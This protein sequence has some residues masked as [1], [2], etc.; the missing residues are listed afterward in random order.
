MPR[1]LCRRERTASMPCHALQCDVHA[2]S[3][4]HT[5]ESGRHASS[6]RSSFVFVQ[7][8][9]LPQLTSHVPVRQMCSAR[10]SLA[11]VATL[12]RRLS[13]RR[14][15]E[16]QAV[17]STGANAGGLFVH[18]HLKIAK[19][20]SELLTSPLRRGWPWRTAS[21]VVMILSGELGYSVA[22]WCG[23]ACARW[24]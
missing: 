10:V 14:L 16:R 19:C 22:N 15:I 21:D 8:S 5:L 6:K 24:P 11:L 23:A 13:V 9:R 1:C 2:R 4:I 18:W 17:H 7:H 12:S 20:D 3:S